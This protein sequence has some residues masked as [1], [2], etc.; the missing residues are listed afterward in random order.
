MA[1]QVDTSV[2][3]NDLMF[4]ALDHGVDSKKNGSAPLVPFV[5]VKNLNGENHAHQFAAETLEESLEKAKQYVDSQKSSIA[6]YAIVWDG[7]LTLDSKKW[8][9][10]LVEAGE[11]GSE[12]GVL[13]AQRCEQ[14]GIFKKKK[15]PVGNPAMINRPA[16]R[17][18]NGKPLT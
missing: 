15:Q 8:D 18:W 1:E 5:M 12:S 17:V 10:I 4:L 14:T 9:A 2:E 7:F 11:Q 16:S 13:L 6:I 3:F